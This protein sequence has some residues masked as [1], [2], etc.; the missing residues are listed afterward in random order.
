MRVS[1]LIHSFENGGA[2]NTLIKLA[3][4][5]LAKGH[6]V[7]ILVMSSAGPLVCRINDGV[8][9]VDLKSPRARSA[10]LPLL[11]AVRELKSEWLITSLLAPSILSL[12]LKI[13]SLGK[14][15]IIIREASTPSFDKPVTIKRFILHY[16]VENLYR[17]SDRV[18]AVSKGVKGD[19]SEFYGVPSEKVDVI[20]NPIIFNG[21]DAV[22]ARRPYYRGPLRLLFVGRVVRI[23]R[24]ELQ[25]E[26]LSIARDQIAGIR[27][28]ICGNYPDPV[29]HKE[30]LSLA[31]KLEV[32]DSITWVGYQ[33]NIYE[34]LNRSDCL[35]LTSD[36]E[37]LPSVLIEALSVGV[38]VIARDCPHGPR[39]ILD[40][41]RI[42]RLIPY[43]S[44]SAIMLASLIVEEAVNP[45]VIDFSDSHIQQFT[46]D[47]IY[48]KYYKLMVR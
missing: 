41:G 10:L 22:R 12:G 21:I 6:D 36:V 40:G 46:S 1:F 34:V 2:Q 25:I 3:N 11:F 4:M 8:S 19:L 47:R 14:V 39:E 38:K 18:V 26:A 35:L 42:G 30:L 16:I 15:R 28:T 9:V 7:S 31:H 43:S 27:L 17:I 48:E 13:L 32:Q 23:K 20:Y 44:C 29:Y 45:S 37:G 33:D 24:I 5:F